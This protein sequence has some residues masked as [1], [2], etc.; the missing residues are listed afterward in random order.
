MYGHVVYG[1]G[2][3]FGF[4]PEARPLKVVALEGKSTWSDPVMGWATVVTHRDGWVID[5]SVSPMIF[6]CGSIVPAGDHYREA[7][8]LKAEGSLAIVPIG[9]D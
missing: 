1:V 8:G 7:H 3:S 5:T 4:V 2:S 6:C 9:Q